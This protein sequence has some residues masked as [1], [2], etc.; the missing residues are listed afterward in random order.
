[1]MMAR[2]SA[3]LGGLIPPRKSTERTTPVKVN[4]PAAGPALKFDNR[5]LTISLVCRADRAYETKKIDTDSPA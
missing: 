4:Q 2:L 1:M 5:L 3:G